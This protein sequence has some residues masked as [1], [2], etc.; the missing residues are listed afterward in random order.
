MDRNDPATTMKGRFTMAE[1]EKKKM[2]CPCTSYPQAG[3]VYVC[4]DCQMT[5]TITRSCSCVDK[6]GV[7]LACCGASMTKVN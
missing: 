2:S 7:C 4:S 3:D 5:V 1:T 6:D